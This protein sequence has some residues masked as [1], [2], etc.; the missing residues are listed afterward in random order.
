MY[1]TVRYYM[2]AMQHQYRDRQIVAIVLGSCSALCVACILVSI[3]IA[4]SAPHLGWYHRPRSTHVLLQDF[5]NYSS[6]FFVLAPAVANFV[7]VFVW[8]N[9][10]DPLN[11]L[12]G[13]CHWDIDVV[14]SGLGGQCQSSPAWGTWLAGA[15]VRLILTVSVIVC[16]ILTCTSL[17]LADSKARPFADRIPRRVLQVSDH[18]TTV[19]PQA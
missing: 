5:L 2:G 11:S 14:W 19:A 12:H 17:T 10:S 7:L 4:A 16:R 9:P 18:T 8:K 1:N 3:I 13:R 6:S 15:L